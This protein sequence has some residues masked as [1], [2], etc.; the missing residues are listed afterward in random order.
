MRFLFLDDAILWSPRGDM[1]HSAL[2]KMVKHRN[3]KSDYIEYDLGIWGASSYIP[4]GWGDD[5][6]FLSPLASEKGLRLSV[7]LFI[8]V[9]TSEVLYDDIVQF[10]NMMKKNGTVVEIREAPNGVHANSGIASNLGMSEVAVEGHVCAATFIARIWEE[11][12]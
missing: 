11:L 9:G 10:A 3:Y 4:P 1:T 7:P 12:E 6:P 8:E 5:H 2:V